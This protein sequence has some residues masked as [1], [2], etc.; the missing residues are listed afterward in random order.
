VASRRTTWFLNANVG[1][2]EHGKGGSSAPGKGRHF[3]LIAAAAVLGTNRAF[4]HVQQFRQESRD[5]LTL[6]SLP[7]NDRRLT[8]RHRPGASLDLSDAGRV[9]GAD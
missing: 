1:H 2:Y 3:K 4:S 8:L 5:K 9:S 6:S 7:I